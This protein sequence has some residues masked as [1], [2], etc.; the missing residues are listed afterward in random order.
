LRRSSVSKIALV[1]DS[2]CDLSKP[3]Q[4]R[5][6]ITIVPLQL[7]LGDE[8]FL[9]GHLTHDEFWQKVKQEAVYPK[10]SQPSPGMFEEAF[11]PLAARGYH[12]ICMTITANYS[13]TFDSASIAAQSFPGQVTVFDTGSASL[14]QG[15]QVIAAARA[16]EAGCGV[17]DVV[18]LLQDNRVRTH[19][20]AYLDTIEF[21]RHGGRLA[22]WIPALDR[23]VRALDIKP[24][25]CVGDGQIRPI[26]ATRSSAKGK[27]RILDEIA[28]RAPAEMLGVLHTRLTDPATALA[29]RLAEQESRPLEGILITEV[30]PALSS[31]GGPGLLG[32]VIMGR[33]A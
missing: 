10:T 15:C 32:A 8:A 17:P 3:L 14:G 9:D 1:S 28:S 20:F 18:Q 19:A 23:M 21:V 7:R 33:S 24:L 25:I 29:R 12:V 26:G 16:I 27:R 2:G 11:A 22:Q 31:H 6:A 13:G 30:G 4:E 5:Y